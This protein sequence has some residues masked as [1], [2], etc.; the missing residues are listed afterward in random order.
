[1]SESIITKKAIAQ[2]LKQLIHTKNFD[3]ISISDITTTCGLNR[4]TFYYHFQDKY[5]LLNW[6]YYNE[7][8]VYVI[9]GITLDN[10]DK[11]VLILLNIMKNDQT[12]YTNTIKYQEQYF[13]NYLFSIT[14]NLFYEAIDQLDDDN[15]LME[16]EKQ[17]YGE[18]FSYGICGVVVS[19]VLK[20]MKEKTSVVA[21]QLKQLM[22]RCEKLGYIRYQEEQIDR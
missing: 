17:F 16:N 4:Q 7:G 14:S 22:L 5:E 3:K 18:F 13:R 2:G 20:G 19:W 8:F 10:W 9:E 6:I 21:G 15:E 1:M 11:Q 12:F